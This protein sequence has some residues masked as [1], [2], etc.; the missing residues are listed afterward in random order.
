MTIVKPALENKSANPK[1]TIVIAVVLVLLAANIVFLIKYSAL[2]KEFIETKKLVES[3]QIN[4]KT[5][6]FTKLFID[7]VLKAE[8]EVSFEDRLQLEN[9]VRNLEDEQILTYWNNFVESKTPEE[10]QNEGR[11]LLDALIKKIS[12]N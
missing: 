11:N 7:K 2:Q 5:L 3:Q 4:E 10:A 6:N 8:G 1:R 9:S 12:T